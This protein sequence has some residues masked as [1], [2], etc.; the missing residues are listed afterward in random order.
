VNTPASSCP[1]GFRT[2][3]AMRC[4][5]AVRQSGKDRPSPCGPYRHTVDKCC[6]LAHRLPTLAGLPG[7]RDNNKCLYPAGLVSR[8]SRVCLPPRVRSCLN[9]APLMSNDLNRSHREPDERRSLRDCL[10]NGGGVC[11]CHQGS[12][13]RFPIKKP[14]I[15][16][17]FNRSSMHPQARPC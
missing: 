15:E 5:S 10:T 16:L 1:T 12:G 17:Q 6:A 4:R 14:N 11:V 7:T 13:N 3:T 2:G 8:P 9:C